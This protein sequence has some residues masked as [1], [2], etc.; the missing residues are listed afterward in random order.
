MTEAGLAMTDIDFFLSHNRAEKAWTRAL[1]EALRSRGATTFFAEVSIAFGEDIVS[2]IGE[3][4]RRSKHIVFVL[5]PRSVQSRWV[6]MEWASAI[7]ADP[8]AHSRRVVPVLKEDCEIPFL[9]QRLRYMDARKSDVTQVATELFSLLNRD[10]A[11][12]GLDRPSHPCY[13]Q[14]KGPLRFGAPQY[15]ERD[16]DYRVA[17][18]LESSESVLVYGPRMVGKTSMLARVAAAERL[19]GTPVIWID[20]Q[21]YYPEDTEVCLRAIADEIGRQVNDTAG[22]EEESS[23]LRIHRMLTEL[24]LNQSSRAVLLVDECDVISSRPAGREFGNL[25]R[26]VLSD[27]ALRNLVCVA[28]GYFPPWRFGVHD[29]LSPWWNLFHLSRLSYFNREEV[30]RL[31][32]WLGADAHSCA[33]YL[34][35]ITGGH[36]GLISMAAYEYTN[37]RGMAELL[38]DPLRPDGPFFPYAWNAVQ[39]AAICLPHRKDILLRLRDGR[40]IPRAR[41]REGLWLVGLTRD[42]QENPPVV[43]GKIFREA[44]ARLLDEETEGDIS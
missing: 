29:V 4:I 18:A 37:G 6:E 41:D 10:P 42:S 38:A 7:Y 25:L 5:S 16:T 22:A 8:D 35:D 14:T 3:G 23:G 39:Y 33:D 28:A 21:G 31:C 20:L 26:M 36:P 24:C 11:V 43:A 40:D 34:A 19:R 1:N 15:V 32:E 9:L 2:A 17:R 30:G 13:V 27:P 44:I 12:A